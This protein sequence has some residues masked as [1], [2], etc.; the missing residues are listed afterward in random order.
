MS[1]IE[2]HHEDEMHEAYL[3]EKERTLRAPRGV[4]PGA[5]LCIHQ[6]LPCNAL[7]QKKGEYRFAGKVEG[8]AKVLRIEMVRGRKCAVVAVAHPRVGTPTYLGA[9]KAV[10]LTEL[11]KQGKSLK[12]YIEGT[13]WYFWPHPY[14]L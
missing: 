5:W 9:E 3:K 14:N 12:N 13:Q 4:K 1:Y 10:P 2:D 11:R 6:D 7:D 8:V